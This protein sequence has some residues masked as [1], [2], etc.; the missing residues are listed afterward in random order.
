MPV[1]APAN[2]VPSIKELFRKRLVHDR[3]AAFLLVFVIA[4]I[5]AAQRNAHH[6]EVTRA[7]LDRD[8]DRQSASAFELRAFDINR[9][10]VV[11]QSERKIV[12]QRGIFD[13]R[14]RL[15]IAR[16]LASETRDRALRCTLAS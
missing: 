12:S 4:K 2:R 14:Q 15:R 16:A 9:A 6:I 8:R 13:L 3:D 1:E 10:V 5:T 11:V 7:A